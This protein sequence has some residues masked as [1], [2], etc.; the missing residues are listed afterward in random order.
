VAAPAVH[1]AAAFARSL[2]EQ[3]GSGVGANV[4]VPAAHPV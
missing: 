2:V 4:V 1:A 3:T